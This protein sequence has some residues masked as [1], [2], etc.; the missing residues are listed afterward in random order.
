MAKEVHSNVMDLFNKVSNCESL[1]MACE[2][3]L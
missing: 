3:W 2:E 1:V